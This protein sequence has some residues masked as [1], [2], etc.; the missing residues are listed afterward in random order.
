M[1]GVQSHIQTFQMEQVAHT[2]GHVHVTIVVVQIQVQKV[3][4][5][6]LVVIHNMDQV[7]TIQSTNVHIVQAPIHQQRL[8]LVHSKVLLDNITERMLTITGISSIV[9]VTVHKLRHMKIIVGLTESVQ[10]VDT[11]VRIVGILQLGHVRSVKWH[12]AILMVQQYITSL[13]QQSTIT[14]RHVR[15]VV[16]FTPVRLQHVHSN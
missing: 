8:N 14:R 1:I 5:I 9:Y 16:M 12:I 3:I 13:E 4:V 11:F 6:Q 2:L 15:V 7:N 10:P